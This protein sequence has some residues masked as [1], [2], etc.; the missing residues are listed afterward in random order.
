M[1]HAGLVDSHCH[2]SLDSFVLDLEAVLARA[3][4]AGVSRIVVPGIDLASSRAAVELAAGH[5]ALQA[6]VG[7]HPHH[8]GSW[9]PGTLDELRDLAQSPGVVAIG[10]I[11]L[12]YV[13]HLS[14]PKAQR[15]VF[16]AQLDLAGQLGL[17]VIV[18]NRQ[19]I[20]DL[21]LALTGW[22]AGLAEGLTDRAGVLHAFS[23]GADEGLAAIEAGFFLGVAGPITFH[24]ADDRRRITAAFP[25][26]RL[27]VE[28]DSPYLSPHP[29]RGQPNEPARVRLIAERLA[30]LVGQTLQD[31]ADATTYNA[32]TLFGWTHGIGHSHLL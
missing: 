16:E 15:S 26:D 25:L 18:H 23:A 31:I 21:L 17:P 20:D 2:L 5:A 10:E 22:S 24:N 8:A 14:P 13:R 19:A 30:E 12:D 3:A 6:A 29:H 7:V 9:Q 1:E 27:L 11:G 28:T 4:E 32:C